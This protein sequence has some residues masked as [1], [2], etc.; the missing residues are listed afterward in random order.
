MS[1]SVRPRQRVRAGHEVHSVPAQVLGGGVQV[2]DVDCQ[3]LYPEVAGSREVLA[4]V[5]RVELEQLDVRAVGTAQEA[6]DLDAAAGGHTQPIP[7]R[8]I[9]RRFTLVEQL[10]AEYVDEKGGCLLYIRHGDAD[11]VYTAQSRALTGRLWEAHP[12]LPS[13]EPAS[14]NLTPL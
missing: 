3:V 8:V 14:V 7:R 12:P 13:S 6:D 11:V 4:L 1:S 9:P 5:G 2:V 10:A